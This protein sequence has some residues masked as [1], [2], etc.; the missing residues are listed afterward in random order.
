MRM[1]L[2]F[3]RRTR[4]ADRRTPLPP[5]PPLPP[6]AP[7]P[8]APPPRAPGALVA[9]P[10]P[11]SPARARLRLAP[12]ARAAGALVALRR[13]VGGLCFAASAPQRR[14]RPARVRAVARHHGGGAGA[15]PHRLRRPLLG[16]PR[17]LP[18]DE[19]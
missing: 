6:P 5:P 16:L 13:R 11:S 14:R 18:P 19:A 4:D 9:P 2:K 7:P 8:P 15:R 10:P 17:P 12:P 3:T 1:I